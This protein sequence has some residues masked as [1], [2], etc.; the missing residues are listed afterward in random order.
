MLLWLDFTN[1][2]F[3]T[4]MF[5]MFLISIYKSVQ[6]SLLKKCFRLV[7]I[8]AFKIYENKK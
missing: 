3:I 4:K 8:K 2:L 5:L 6:N 7:L 1:K